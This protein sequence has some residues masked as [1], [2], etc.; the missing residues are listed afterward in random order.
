LL[1]TAAAG[2]LSQLEYI[3]T[4]NVHTVFQFLTRQREEQRFAE[5]LQQV[6]ADEAKAKRRL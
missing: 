1:Y 4:L 6:Y 3:K 2:Q 5:R